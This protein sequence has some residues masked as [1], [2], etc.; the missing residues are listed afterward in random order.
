VRFYDVWAILS[1]AFEGD[2]E[3]GG[4]TDHSLRNRHEI[5]ANTFRGFS[6]EI[7]TLSGVG[8]ACCQNSVMQPANRTHAVSRQGRKNE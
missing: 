8:P 3:H 1:D 2:R 7:S 6:Q 4:I 5:D